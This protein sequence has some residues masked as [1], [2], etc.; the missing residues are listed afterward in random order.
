M[1][2]TTYV[3]PVKIFPRLLACYLVLLAGTG[4]LD[5]IPFVSFDGLNLTVC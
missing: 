1:G 5:W 3:R 4:K 2:G